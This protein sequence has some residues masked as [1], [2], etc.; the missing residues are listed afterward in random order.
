MTNLKDINFGL[1]QSSQE[2]K[3]YFDMR[4]THIVVVGDDTPA[5]FL[6]N[7]VEL[8]M[9]MTEEEFEFLK[10]NVINSLPKSE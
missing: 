10:I 6:Y 3:R 4:L 8:I 1:N 2:S 7:G 5:W 9:H